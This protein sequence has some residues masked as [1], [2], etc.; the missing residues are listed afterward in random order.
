MVN[1]GDVHIEK[2]SDCLVAQ[3]LM[4]GLC[5]HIRRVRLK[6]ALHRMVSV[7]HQSTARAIRAD[8]TYAFECSRG[9][10]MSYTDHS[11][12]RCFK[13]NAPTDWISQHCLVIT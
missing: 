3:F 8:E 1:N 11:V 5:S 7:R 4:F 6:A 2:P 9:T 13:S 10:L 12:Q